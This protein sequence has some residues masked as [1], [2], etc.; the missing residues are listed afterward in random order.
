LPAVTENETT[1]S[2]THW[3]AEEGGAEIKL[4]TIHGGGHTWPG[5]DP[6]MDLMGRYTNDINANQLI[7]E[8]FQQHPLCT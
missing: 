3:T 4:Y 8:F 1:V 7:W 6:R 2:L 5:R